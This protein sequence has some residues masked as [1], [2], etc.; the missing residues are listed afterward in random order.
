MI[1][2]YTKPRK[3]YMMMK[4]KTLNM[5]QGNPTK[6]LIIFAIPM[7]LGNI[8]QQMYNLVDSVIV[9]RFVGANA[10]AAIGATN[11]VSFLFFY[12]HFL[13]KK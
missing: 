11:S 7:L 1:C 6:L 13:S 9:G 3:K 5:T 8:F 10:L 12:I 4:S 2:S